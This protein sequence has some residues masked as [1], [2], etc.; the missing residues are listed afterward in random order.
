MSFDLTIIAV[1][2]TLILLLVFFSAIV[3]YLSFRL[4]ETFRKETKRGAIIAKAAFLIG[5]L[6]L[7]GGIFYFAA[8][9]LTNLNPTDQPTPTTSPTPNATPTN[10]P[11]QSPTPTPTA[12]PSVS[13]TPT[14]NSPVSFT[15]FYP[16]STAMD[17]QITMTFNI[18]NPTNTALKNAAIQTNTLFQYF[19]VTSSTHEV[20]ANIINIG[21]LAPGTTTVTLQLKA[22]NRPAEVNDSIALIHQGIQNQVTQQISITVRGR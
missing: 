8:S 3:L 17:S 9:S 18:I 13:S 19:T 15:A 1:V 11:S 21:D 7:A 10:P 2:F 20:T 12:S 22:P 5:I 14:P 6:F 16:T 4:K